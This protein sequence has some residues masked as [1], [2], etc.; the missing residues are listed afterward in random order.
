MT[1]PR[2]EAVA[3]LAV[4]LAAGCGTA[5]EPARPAPYSFEEQQTGTIF[6]WP[7]DRLP[8][9]YWVDPGAGVVADYV[10]RALALWEEQFLYAEFRGVTVADSARADVIVRVIGPTPPDVPLTNDEPVFACGGVTHFAPPD[11]DNRFPG[12]PVV[13]LEWDDG[14]DEVDV[15]NCLSRVAAHEIGHTLGILAHSP[16]DFDLMNATPVVTAPSIRDRIT[17]ETL[18]HTAPNV[19]PPERPR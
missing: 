9:R 3:A 11:A 15:V 16:D 10:S 14:Y 17:A 12:P 4:L 19:L 2:S 13:E 5:A 7:A 1:G 8:V 6:S 18:Y